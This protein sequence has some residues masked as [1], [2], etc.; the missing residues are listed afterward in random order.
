MSTE[1]IAV[2]NQKGG[3]GK[4]TTAT[5][6][7]AA[8]AEM[9]YKV[10]LVDLDPQACLSIGLGINP[11]ELS[12]S[13]HDVFADRVGMQEIIHPTRPG[14]HVAPATID[15][16]AAEMEL[17][18]A[19]GREYILREALGP[20]RHNYDYIFLDC[21]PNLGLLTINA[22]TA[23]DKVLI[24]LQC[25]YLALR[26]MAVLLNT[27]EKVKAK[28]NPGL[29]LLGILPTMYS[30]R[31]L[32]AREVLEQIKAMFGDKVYDI[33]IRTSIRFAEA[34]VAY[35]SILE[36]ESTHDGAMAYRALAEVISHGKKKSKR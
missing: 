14:L 3:V 35:Q 7:G 2:A 20:V 12:E 28:L 31:T 16:A 34:P 19:L 5:N 15:L 10:L 13:L 18:S 29:E 32:H 17:V 4:T 33:V 25:E 6:L 21:G 30:T 1:V 8:L 22:L 11:Y 27:I 24:P 9:G 36:Y 23:A 26:G